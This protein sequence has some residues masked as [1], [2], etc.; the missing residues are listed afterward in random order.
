MKRKIF[1]IAYITFFLVNA[2]IYAQP[3]GRGGP[4]GGPGPGAPGG[5]APG[6]KGG[7]AAP[8]PSAPSGPSGRTNG[9]HSV[10]INPNNINTK[11][12]HSFN[13]MR[14]PSKHAPFQVVHIESTDE[15][16]FVT[17]NIPL[18]PST[19]KKA[20]ILINGIPLDSTATLRFNKTGRILEIK[21]KLYV[22]TR[23]SLE[24]KNVKSYDLDELKVK[25]FEFLLPWTS[26]EYPAIKANEK[27]D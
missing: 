15:T 24:F 26:S 21:T 17:F 8:G 6:G 18:N 27:G 20:N 12:T 10:P 9:G 23:F 22:G 25:K 3:G 16:I 1:F 14:L 11:D 13:G 5:G 7:P 4:G 19:C 2:L